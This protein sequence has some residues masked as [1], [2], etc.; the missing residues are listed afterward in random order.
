MI[1]K[2]DFFFF[3]PFLILFGQNDFDYYSVQN[4]MKFAD[5][6]F[7]TKDYLRAADEYY[8]IYSMNNNDTILFKL[9]YSNASLKNFKEALSNFRK[10]TDNS[11]RNYSLFEEIK[12]N[13]LLKD[14]KKNRENYFNLTYPEKIGKLLFFSNLLSNESYKEFDFY[15]EGHEKIFVRNLM[16]EKEGMKL[17][18]KMF[19]GILS[20]IIPG[21]GKIYSER[22]TDGISAFLLNSLFG[23][24][25][26]DR[27]KSE[28]YL[29]AGIFSTLFVLFYGGN[30]Y[31]S[32]VAAENYNLQLNHNFS[33]KIHD[34][35]QK[36]N[37][38]NY[39]YS[40]I[41]KKSK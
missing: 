35:L 27:I 36:K 4:R 10:I 40:E 12:I 24:L 17:K 38:Y 13:F 23:Y 9:A 5:Y 26:Y 37:Y 32:V 6:L 29:S 14:Y 7:N 33:N 28:R 30:I 2:I 22:Y 34:Y 41:F 15:F 19:S 16:A 20:G 8:E 21:L 1:K 11:L 18:N 31:G 39:D 3:F 25:S